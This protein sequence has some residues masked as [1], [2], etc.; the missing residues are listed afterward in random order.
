MPTLK[1]LVVRRWAIFERSLGK[2]HPA[3][4]AVLNTW[5][6]LEVELGRPSEAQTYLEEGTEDRRRHLRRRERGRRRHV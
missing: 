3:V 4:G 6:Q 1:R 5:G 2:E